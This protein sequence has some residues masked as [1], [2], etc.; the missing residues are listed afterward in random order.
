MGDIPVI[1]AKPIQ[2]L[3]AEVVRIASI[4]VSGLT[5]TVHLRAAFHVA[6][7][8]T[9]QIPNRQAFTNANFVALVPTIQMLGL[10][11]VATVCRAQPGHRTQTVGPAPEAPALHAALEATV[12]EAKQAAPSAAQEGSIRTADPPPA[13]P[14]ASAAL[15]ATATLANRAAPSAALAATTQ[16]VVLAAAAPAF[17]A[18]PVASIPTR[19]RTAPAPAFPAAL[20]ATIPTLVLPAVPRVLR[21]L[22]VRSL[23]TPAVVPTPCANQAQLRRGMATRSAYLVLL[24]SLAAQATQ[25][26]AQC[27]PKEHTARQLVR[28]L[29]WRVCRAR[30]VRMAIKTARLTRRHAFH[31]P[32]A[33]STHRPDPPLQQP[34]GSAR[35]GHL[36]LSKGRRPIRSAR[37][38][39][40]DRMLRMVARRRVTSV[41]REHTVQRKAPCRILRAC[42]AEPVRSAT[43]SGQTRRNSVSRA[44]LVCSARQ[45]APR[46]AYPVTL[47]TSRKR[48][49]RQSASPALS[50]LSTTYSERTAQ[51][52]AFPAP[53]ERTE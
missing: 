14:V 12:E 40:P 42:R 19:A 7:A 51:R 1:Q 26:P 36:A 37:S 30:W 35:R 16:P 11:V 34:V 27:A 3:E 38:A 13:V 29:L 18:A 45:L 2:T 52:C 50:A 20:A 48:C 4:A 21:R 33:R 24:V 15:E 41:D 22:L 46:R 6:L 44:T 10:E 25:R 28:T 43:R 23:S 31:V 5:A 8:V 17:P 53:A 9:T 39:P 49:S 47:G 32:Q